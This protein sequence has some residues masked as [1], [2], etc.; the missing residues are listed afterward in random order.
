MVAASVAVAVAA[1]SSMNKNPY[2]F[3]VEDKFAP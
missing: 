1:R 3:A 2:N